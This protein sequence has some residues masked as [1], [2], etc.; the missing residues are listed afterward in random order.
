M[1]AS[2]DDKLADSP[3]VV[4][5]VD[6]IGEKVGDRLDLAW[7]LFFVPS[8]HLPG[9][10]RPGNQH[11]HAPTGHLLAVHRV[12]AANREP[13]FCAR[14]ALRR[15][16][17]GSGHAVYGGFPTYQPTVKGNRDGPQTAFRP[18]LS[19]PGGRQRKHALIDHLLAL[20]R[21]LNAD[22]ETCFYAHRALCRTD[23]YMHTR[24]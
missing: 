12:L 7:Y 21:A 4:V 20:H 23:A 5:I 24:R 6:V 1:A 18:H 14:R 17:G 19:M 2:D 10:V 16:F 3:N 9:S 8:S 22:R 11:K 13:C 15:L